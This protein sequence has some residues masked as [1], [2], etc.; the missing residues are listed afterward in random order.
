MCSTAVA[1]TTWPTEEDA[2]SISG[3]AALTA[4]RNVETALPTLPRDRRTT[5]KR[6]KAGWP[7]EFEPSHL[8]QKIEIAP[9]VG[10]CDVLEEHAAIAA[11][12]FRR[13]GCETLQPPLDFRRR[14]AQLD[15][16][17]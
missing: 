7:P 14:D 13:C 17:A 6:Q 5:G 8:A 9:Q 10:L 4:R 3:A 11:I 15:L 2:V 16:P 12:I 1:F